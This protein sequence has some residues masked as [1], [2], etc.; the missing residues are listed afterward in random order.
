MA[1]EGRTI[2]RHYSLPR[3]LEVGGARTGA[4]AAPCLTEE[5]TGNPG[6]RTLSTMWVGMEVMFTSQ[7]VVGTTVQTSK[8]IG[9]VAAA[10]PMALNLAE[11]IMISRMLSLAPPIS[12]SRITG[13]GDMEAVKAGGRSL[14][15]TIPIA[16]QGVVVVEEDWALVAGVLGEGAEWGGRGTRREK[17]VLGGV[18]EVV[19]A[20]LEEQELVTE[21]L[22]KGVGFGLVM[23]TA[24][25]VVASHKGVEPVGW[26]LEEEIGVL[27]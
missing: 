14:E 8:S 19:L 23:G 15:G 2:N 17:E 1:R 5:P 20:T 4:A 11:G 25:L 24:M 7:I 3:T 6:H 22:S 18:M 10:I 21:V 16:D 13:R 12:S 27:I 26:V 9:R